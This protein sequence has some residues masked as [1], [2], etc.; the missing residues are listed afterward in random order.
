MPSGKEYG[1]FAVGWNEKVNKKWAEHTT[2]VDKK[3]Q[4]KWATGVD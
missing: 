1:E 2:N 3:K 4:L